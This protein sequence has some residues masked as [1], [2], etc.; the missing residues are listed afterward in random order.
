MKKR[1]FFFK[2]SCASIAEKLKRFSAE[3]FLLRGKK[4]IKTVLE[5][6]KNQ[7]RDYSLQCFL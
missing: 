4:F 2:R 3:S 6:E 5:E 7:K 1:A